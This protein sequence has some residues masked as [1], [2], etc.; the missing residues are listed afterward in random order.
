MSSFLSAAGGG[1]TPLNKAN[2]LTV[3]PMYM[4]KIYNT[5][6]QE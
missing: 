5:K 1:V 6:N 2:P 4:V 3:D